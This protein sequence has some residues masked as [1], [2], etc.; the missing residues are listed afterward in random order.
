MFIFTDAEIYS[1][2]KPAQKVRYIYPSCHPS[3]IFMAHV[4]A[5]NLNVFTISSPLMVMA[6]LSAFLSSLIFLCDFIFLS[7]TFLLLKVLF[8]DLKLFWPADSVRKSIMSKLLSFQ[9]IRQLILGLRGVN[10][11]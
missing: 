2:G 4:S 9:L 8:D 5:Q 1:E 7:Y 3:Q 6:F 11:I 10:F